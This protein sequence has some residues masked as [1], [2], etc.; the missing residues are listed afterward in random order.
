MKTALA[1]LKFLTFVG[2]FDRNQVNPQQI[3]AAIPYF[4][5]VGIFL[6]FILVLLN[7]LLDPRLESE[8]LG[9]LLIGVLALLTGGI[10]YQGLQNTFD[11]LSVKP[12]RGEETGRS[13]VLGV[14][15]IVFVVLLKVRAVEVTG[16][17]RS[18]GLLLTP[19]FA[20]WSLVIFLSSADS[21]SEGAARLVTDNVQ[22]WHLALTTVVTLAIAGILLE[23][24]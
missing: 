7:R 1:A 24:T 15:A 23:G 16:E 4:P 10:H 22:A 6:G 18:L 17:T 21:G 19:L 14:L 3:S 13:H 9:A 2:R 11:A 8:I 20:R 5:L 12:S